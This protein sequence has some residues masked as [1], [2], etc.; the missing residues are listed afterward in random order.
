M[1]YKI[2]SVC[3]KENSVQCPSSAVFLLT[4]YFKDQ[5]VLIY[6]VQVCNVC[7]IT[8]TTIGGHIDD[9]ILGWGVGGEAHDTS[10]Q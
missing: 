7:L 9:F 8:G 2:I 6:F 1:Y 4:L 3:G 10:F 5:I